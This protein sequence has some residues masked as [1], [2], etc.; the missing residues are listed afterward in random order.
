[1]S[2]IW[3]VAKINN[4]CKTN[5]F[6]YV[7]LELYAVTRVSNFHSIALIINAVCIWIEALT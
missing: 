2:Q 3:Y 7:P 4:V 6:S 1:M 5:S